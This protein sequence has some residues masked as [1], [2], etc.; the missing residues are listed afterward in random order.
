MAQAERHQHSRRYPELVRTTLDVDSYVRPDQFEL[1]R[2]K[3]FKKS[4]LNV[5]RVEQIPKPGDY[6]Y[7]RF[8]PQAVDRTRWFFIEWT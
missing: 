7:F 3:I 4:W 8:R 1:E 5:G 2:A 6:S